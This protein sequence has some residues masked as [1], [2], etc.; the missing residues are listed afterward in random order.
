MF[1]RSTP[2]GEI[3]TICSTRGNPS[4][5]EHYNMFYMEQPLLEDSATKPRSPKQPHTGERK[6]IPDAWG[7]PES[8][9]NMQHLI[10]FRG[11]PGGEVNPYTRR[12]N[13][14]Y[15]M[16]NERYVQENPP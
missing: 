13:N 3:I 15:Y 12:R 10:P 16:G 14:P 1:H 6:V 9:R 8:S 4:R 2:L 7:N 11:N 5:G